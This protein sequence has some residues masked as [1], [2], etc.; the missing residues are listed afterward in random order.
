MAVGI[1][2]RVMGKTLLMLSIILLVG[3]RKELCDLP[4]PH[5]QQVTIAI[6]WSNAYD[7]V[8]PESVGVLFYPIEKSSEGEHLQK[9]A[10]KPITYYLP[11][12]GGKVNLDAGYYAA[13][14]Y[15]LDT[16]KILF[17]KKEKYNQMEAYTEPMFRKSYASRTEATGEMT[18]EM[19]DLL[20][21]D[22]I[23]LLEILP[24]E[25]G[26]RE[27]CVVF[28]PKPAVMR[29]H[30][31]VRV[32]GIQYVASARGALSQMAGGYMLGHGCASGTPVTFFYDFI[33]KEGTSNELYAEVWTFGQLP[34]E[35]NKRQI[36]TIELLLIDGSILPFTFDVTEDIA[37]MEHNITI[38]LGMNG[39][40]DIPP[41]E[42]PGGGFEGGIGDWEEEIIVPLK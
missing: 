28:T 6:D 18:V 33:A 10:S 26:V 36:L 14:L 19:P 11:A 5:P 23:D 15:N 4:H 34:Q 24:D 40:V 42:G 7:S 41:V 8:V 38:T 2:K 39:E 30:V 3:C 13:I 29:L 32:N 35:M 20:Y 12:T 1:V 21:G 37:K 27:Q 22:N 16:E 25:S 17:R 9:T 31:N